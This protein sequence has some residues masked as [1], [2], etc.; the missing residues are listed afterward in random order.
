VGQDVL[1]RAYHYHAQ[2]KRYSKDIIIKTQWKE[3][4]I[5]LSY[6]KKNY[7]IGTLKGLHDTHRK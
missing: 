3:S 6:F 1:C 5:H 4:G 7:T 2:N